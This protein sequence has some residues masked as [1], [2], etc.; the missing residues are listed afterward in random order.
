MGKTP[1]NLAFGT[2]AVILVKFELPSFKGE[3]YNEDTNSMWL[4]A[5]LDLIE[6]SR[7]RAAVR[8]AICH[9][10]IDGQIL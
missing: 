5:N 9:Q 7:E 1:F 4:S 6:E 3:E 8:M 2:K 10:R